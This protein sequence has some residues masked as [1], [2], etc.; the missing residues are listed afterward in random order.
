[1][2]STG[3]DKRYVFR[4]FIC[5]IVTAA[6]CVAGEDVAAQDRGSESAETVRFGVIADA[7]YCD[8]AVNGSRHYRASPGKMRDAIEQLNGEDLDFVIHLGDL[9][10]RD[11]ESFGEILPIYRELR[12]PTYQVLGNHDFA[13][14]PSM[15][16]EV[17]RRLGLYRRYYD[18]VVGS[19]R[20]V[21]L[22]TNDLSLYARGEGTA[23]YRR[24]DSLFQYLVADDR[25][26]AKEWN[27]GVSREQLRWL[28][29]TLGEAA[30]RD[31]RVVVFTHHPVYPSNAHNVWNDREVLEVL[32]AHDNAAAV[33]SG[34]NHGGNYGAD[35]G[36][37]FL[38]LKGMVETPDSTAY[39][40]VEASA[41]RLEVIGFGRE[42]DRIFEIGRE[43]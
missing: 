36:I 34:H 35:R 26:N 30:A 3:I 4:L 13:V 24:A 20:F 28:D 16:D 41:D 12:V 6:L 19:W 11:F 21:V 33:M 31:E 23:R 39:A 22:D 10:D 29:R 7:Q 2:K 9:I 37:H 15:K 8:C 40:V 43:R 42:V 25:P 38:T 5:V 18:F 1:M 27:G 17:V 14:D 32:S